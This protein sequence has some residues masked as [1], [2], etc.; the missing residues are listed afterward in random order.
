MGR[1]VLMPA[2]EVTA[3]GTRGRTAIAMAAAGLWLVVLSGPAYAVADVPGYR[4]EE[5]RKLAPGVEYRRIVRPNGPVVVHAVAM[6]RGAGN[7]LRSVLSNDRVAGPAPTQERTSAMC[8]RVRCIAAVNGDFAFPAGEPVGG[9]VAAGQMLRSPVPTQHQLSITSSGGLEAGTLAWSAQLVPSDLRPVAIQGLNVDRPADTLVLYT[10]AYGPATATNGFGAELVLRVVE[11]ATSPQVGHTGLVELVGFVAG[12]G[13]SP[14]PVGGLV[15]SGHGTGASAL[16]DLWGRREKGVVSGRAL[17]RVETSPQVSES[18]GGTPILVHEGRRWV[19]EEASTFVT[20]RHPRTV[21]GWNDTEVLLVTVDGRQPGYSVGMSLPEAADLLLALGATEALNLDGG[22]STTLAVGASVVNRPSD[23]LVRRAG[24]EQIVHDLAPGDVLVGSVERPVASGLAIVPAGPT[25]TSPADPLA[26][27][28]PLVL[29]DVEPPAYNTDP[30][31]VP[32][33]GN[34]ALLNLRPPP[35]P[36]AGLIAVAAGLE[37][38]VAQW[39]L[40]IA[41]SRRR[42]SGTRS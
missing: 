7:V 18:V 26:A 19:A 20:G 37:V 35:S 23:R 16:A 2:P 15:L 39:L 4:T 22:G 24:K 27:G 28:D 1:L 29:L 36:S 13:N 38:A 41:V 5:V 21:V 11:P 12:G 9:A 42:R 30:A 3:M 25:G 32:G 31:S 40:I 17:L 33:A 6:Q 10:P 34:L 8:Q 14:I